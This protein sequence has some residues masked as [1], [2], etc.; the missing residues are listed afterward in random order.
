M[1]ILFAHI[2]FFIFINIPV[3]GQSVGISA[4]QITPHSSSILEIHSNN[5]GLLIPRIALTGKNDNTTIP[6]PSSSLMVYNTS[7][8]GGLTLGYYYWSGSSWLAF[9]GTSSCVNC[10]S[11]TGN[12]STT[13]GVHFLGTSDNNPFNI[14][15]NNTKSGKIDHL[16]NNTFLG[17]RSGY[18][19]TNG[20][21]NSAIG[22]DALKNNLIGSNNSV[23]GFEAMANNTHG[24]YNL[25]I[26][27]M[28]LKN[29]SYSNQNIAIGNQALFTQNF[30]N[31]NSS[32]NTENIAIGYQSLYS[33]NP[34]QNT[35]GQKNI[36]IGPYS[37]YNNTTGNQNIAIGDY[38]LNNNITGF[39]NC[40]AGANTMSNANSSGN[41]GLGYFLAGGITSGVNNTMFGG[42]AGDQIFGQSENNILLGYCAGRR[43]GLLRSCILIGRNSQANLG[44]E[45]T[46]NIGIG[47]QVYNGIISGNYNVAI[48]TNADRALAGGSNNISL[49]HL[50]G[51][52]TQSNK[53]GSIFLGHMAGGNTT[54]SN[55]LFIENNNN[56]LNPLIFGNFET[57]QFTIKTSSSFAGFDVNGDIKI[58]TNG[59]AFSSIV[60]WDPV[61][62][63]WFA[64]NNGTR[65]VFT[66]DVFNISPENSTVIL[67][68][69]N[70]LP[71]IIIEYA[72]VSAPNTIEISLLNRSG[73]SYNAFEFIQ[74]FNVAVI[75]Y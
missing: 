19:L 40:V 47:D 10:W 50:S 28:A 65:Y 68:P 51:G 27:V 49:G 72:R 43:R 12:A 24:S 25:S 42:A 63:N 17:Y 66:K 46:S 60:C 11:L 37:L 59:N 58:G 29:N 45:N 8:L 21:N 52:T 57:G 74:T 61:I 44:T 73:V 16:L 33:N 23:V 55:V 5:K 4:S 7:S 9:H 70:S 1:R 62:F 20:T 75:K 69:L 67:S 41:V 2:I 64:W 34:T 6:N 35:N 3:N 38:S 14:R 53:T 18:S 56:T 15:V 54:N 71:G 32:W 30:S 39:D 31:F 26:G 13:E 22:S 48:G 36:A